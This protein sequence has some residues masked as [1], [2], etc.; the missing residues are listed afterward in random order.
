M[1]IYRD[2]QDNQIFKRINK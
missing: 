2:L 1:L